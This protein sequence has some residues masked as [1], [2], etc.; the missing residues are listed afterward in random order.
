MHQQRHHLTVASRNV[1]LPKEFRSGKVGHTFAGSSSSPEDRVGLFTRKKSVSPS[2]L[3]PHVWLIATLNSVHK[4]AKHLAA[5]SPVPE[6]EIARELVVAQLFFGRLAFLYKLPTK[7]SNTYKECVWIFDLMQ[8]SFTG[9]I[10]SADVKL[11][12]IALP[13]M[14]EVERIARSQCNLD[15]Y[16]EHA[17]TMR[18]LA[19]QGVYVSRR[20]SEFAKLHK[21]GGD[22]KAVNSSI[23]RLFQPNSASILSDSLARLE[24]KIVSTMEVLM[25]DIR[26]VSGK[27]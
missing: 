1:P 12:A 16:S 7:N 2:K 21:P 24:G 3:L 19:E 4:L 5:L 6:Q 11:N 9:Q 25:D 14:L 23:H 20:L 15:E 8:L 22:T 10:E 18:I 13:L 17:E 26:I 27:P